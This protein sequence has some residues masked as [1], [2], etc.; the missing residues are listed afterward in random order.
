MNS[1]DDRHLQKI[2]YLAWTA[3]PRA[4]RREQAHAVRELAAAIRRWARGGLSS[5]GHAGR[6]EILDEAA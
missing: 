3:G 6:D 1:A 5:L 4:A 2:T